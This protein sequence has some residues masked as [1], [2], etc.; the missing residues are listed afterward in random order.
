VYIPMFECPIGTLK[1]HE[2]SKQV[3]E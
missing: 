3:G 2:V 1:A